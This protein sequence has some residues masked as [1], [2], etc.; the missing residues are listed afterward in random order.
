MKS[1][2]DNRTFPDHVDAMSPYMANL[3]PLFDWVEFAGFR[4]DFRESISK[5]IEAVLPSA[6]RQRSPEHLDGMLGEQERIDDTVQTAAR[7]DARRFRL[8]RECR[9]CDRAR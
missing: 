8:R 4:E 1:L 5:L 6:I 9:G 7:R 3:C 2:L